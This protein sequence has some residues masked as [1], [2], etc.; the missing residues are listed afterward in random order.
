MKKRF[1]RLLLAVPSSAGSTAATVVFAA[2]ASATFGV[3]NRFV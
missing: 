3:N 1:E 2:A